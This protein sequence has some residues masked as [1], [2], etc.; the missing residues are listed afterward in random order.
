MYVVK[1]PEEKIFSNSHHF[2]RSKK[3]RMKVS[4]SQICHMFQT[5]LPI[6]Q[7]LACTHFLKSQ[8]DISPTAE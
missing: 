4:F 6:F 5:Y 8:Q 7:N 2:Q 3:C 1:I